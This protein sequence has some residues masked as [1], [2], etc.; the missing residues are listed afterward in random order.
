MK[1]LS[2][3]KIIFNKFF[4]STV[5]SIKPHSHRIHNTRIV[6]LNLRKVL[7]KIKNDISF[8]HEELQRLNTS[9]IDYEFEV[10]KHLRC[11]NYLDAAK[12]SVHIKNIKTDI[13]NVQKTTESLAELKTSIVDKISE[14][15]ITSSHR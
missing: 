2:Y 6:L 8:N 5:G 9:L 1:L 10:K 11:D 12:A 4:K 14:I 3:I 13:S 15:T 7:L